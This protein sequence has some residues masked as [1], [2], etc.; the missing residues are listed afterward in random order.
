MIDAGERLERALALDPNFAPAW[1][2]MAQVKRWDGNAPGAAG[3]KA[4]DDALL[5]AQRA[6]ALAPDLAEAHGVLGM[7]LG[8]E[9]PAGQQHI[10]RA[11]ALDPTNPEF[12]FWLGHVYTNESNFPAMLAAYRRAFSLDPLWNQAHYYAVLAAWRMERRDE[13]IGYVRRV[14]R[15]GSR[16]DTH[17]LGGLL[18]ASSGDLSEAA[19]RFGAARAATADLGKQAIAVYSRGGIFYQLGM[20]DAA[21]K[22]W[23]SCQH[24][25]AKE[26]KRALGMP[27]RHAAHFVLR[28]GK[29]PTAAELA[30]VNRSGD[31]VGNDLVAAMAKKLIRAG[32]AGE[33]VAL[34]DSEEGVLG[35]SQRRPRPGSF[36]VALRS[37]PIVASAL[38][39][40]GRT[41]EADRLLRQAD[42]LIQD[43]LRRSGGQTPADF[44]ADAAQTWALLGKRESALAGLERARRNGWINGDLMAGD[45]VDDIADEPAFS[46]LRGDPRFETIRARMN[47]HLAR[48]RRELAAQ[49]ARTA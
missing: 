33:V 44:Y 49:M 13:A 41:G 31:P 48:E 7:I 25:W 22:E 35:L 29:L 32:R 23:A 4:R 21:R 2:S 10:K 11:A 42:R 24:F 47:A 14:E 40:S 15:E 8:F 1:S 20:V 12:Q 17:M 28:Q 38:S 34:Y 36:D 18:A 46:G 45:L 39:A 27:E 43:A 3:Q 5:Y 30:S 9:D 16:Y 37:A 19:L 6:L 26:N